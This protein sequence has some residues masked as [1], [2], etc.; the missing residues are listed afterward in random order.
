MLTRNIRRP[1]HIKKASLSFWRTSA[2]IVCYFFSGLC[3]PICELFVCMYV[4]TRLPLLLTANLSCL[5]FLGE[6][7]IYTFFGKKQVSERFWAKIYK[8]LVGISYICLVNI[9][10]TFQ[11]FGEKYQALVWKV[12]YDRPFMDY[13]GRKKDKVF[14]EKMR[15]R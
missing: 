14:A 13:I 2:G 12:N 9:W 5:F 4:F 8:N 6:V 15:A 10:N 7:K 11:L 3:D 1:A